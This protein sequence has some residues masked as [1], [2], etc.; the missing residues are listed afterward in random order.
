M[1]VNPNDVNKQVL[2]LMGYGIKVGT[3]NGLLKIMIA[4]QSR[5]SNRKKNDANN[6]SAKTRRSTWSVSP[7]LVSGVIAGAGTSFTPRALHLLLAEGVGVVHVKRGIVIGMTLPY[8]AHGTVRLRKEQ[9]QASYS[10]RGVH[11]ACRIV[12]AGIN[13]KARLLQSLARNRK[14]SAPKLE[15]KLQN[16]ATSLLTLIE[17]IHDLEEDNPDLG[18]DTLRMRIMGIEGEATALYYEALRWIFP[19]KWNFSGRTK[20]PPRDPIN[21]A[22]SYGYVL[23][24]ARMILMTVSTGLDP[25]C[26]YLHAD[27]SGRRSLALDLAEPFR[28]PIIDRT[29]IDLVVHKQLKIEED[30]TNE[31]GA[32]YLSASGKQ[33]VIQRI[34]ERLHKEFNLGSTRTTYMQQIIAQANNLKR[35]LLG[36]EPRFHPF[37]MRW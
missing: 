2:L 3:E 7:K 31:D 10:H 22:L 36:K 26:G 19:S 16:C 4:R 30:F 14:H 6:L 34:E 18:M 9:Y 21:A 32:C 37:L 12:E 11:V 27:R 13:N 29:V 8:Q 15:E 1:P 28:Q 23:L 17:P 33:K 35:F 24:A 5:H 20:R 25:F